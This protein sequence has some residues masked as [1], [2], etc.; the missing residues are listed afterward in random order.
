METPLFSI[1]VPVYKTEAFLRQCV[2]SILN[3]TYPDFQLVLVDD[4]SPDG[5]GAI[6]DEYAGLDNR[7]TVVHKENGGLVSARKA[8]AAVCCGTYVVNVDSDDYIAPNHLA[9][10]AEVIESYAPDALLFSVTRFPEPDRDAVRTLLP[11]GLY[12]GEKLREIQQNL[13]C[14]ENLRQLIAYG[15]CLTAMK[16]ELYTPYQ[17]AAPG[18]IIRGEDVSVTVP[19][20]ASSS[21]V[22]VLDHCGYFYRNNP[23]SSQNTFRKDEVQQIKIL[24]SHLRGALDATYYGRID[25]YVAT[26]YFDFLDRAML[27]M[28]YDQYRHL[29]KETMDA[30]LYSYLTRAKC[31]NNRMWQIVFLLMRYKMFGT[32]WMVRK[33]RKRKH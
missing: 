31:K 12:T 4:G 25:M 28:N 8:G 21:S 6:C 14:S 30:E 2:D 20:L 11:A 1:I 13:I 33:I 19:L 27:L 5:S 18:N 29:V 9:C 17:M 23:A 26:H 32:L 7:V 3:Q 22:Y 16:R 15:I 10:L 24:A